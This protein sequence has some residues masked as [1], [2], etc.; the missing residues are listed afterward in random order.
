MVTVNVIFTDGAEFFKKLFYSALDGIVNI[1]EDTEKPVHLMI[2][3]CFGNN[4]LSF[5]GKKLFVSGEN[6][7]PDFNECDYAITCHNIIFDDRHYK[8]PFFVT[9]LEYRY[10]NQIRYDN[11]NLANKEFCSAVISNHNC[12]DPNRLNIIQSI[13]DNYKS[14]KLYGKDYEPIEKRPI[15]AENGESKITN[16]AKINTISKFKFSIAF[17][18][19][20][21]PGYVTEKITDSFIART[22]PIYWG[23]N[24]VIEYFN[25]DS[26]INVNDYN[27]I[28]DLI[29]YIKYLDEHDDEFLEKL[30]TP[31]VLKSYQI[32]IDELKK[33]LINV[34]NGNIYN[35]KYGRIGLINTLRKNATFKK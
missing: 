16:I 26:Y 4:H 6:I 31:K 13:S 17:E 33:F 23:T 35:K 2:Y 9:Q 14:I 30:K 24:T 12:D 3:S 29:A 18:N 28:E 32:Y 21:I 20:D 25:K 5:E 8:L 10:L 7:Y 11:Y 34:F 15:N 22:I 19:S 27:S 1:E